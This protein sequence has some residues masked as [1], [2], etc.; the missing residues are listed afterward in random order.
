MTSA[1]YPSFPPGFWRRIELYPAPRM[2]IAGL[3]DDVHRFLMRLSHHE[4]MIMG[5]EARAERFPW[6]TVHA[7]AARHL[8]FRRGQPEHSPERAAD[9]PGR[10]G[11]CFTYQMP[12]ARDATQR[13]NWR[14]D[15]SGSDKG[16]LQ[17]FDPE[18]MKPRL[19]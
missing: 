19:R 4:G 5:V 9:R 8:C 10:I 17:G 12:R 18:L 7:D 13:Q 1:A 16:P 2:I 14:Q 11:A 6:S 3:D 15:F